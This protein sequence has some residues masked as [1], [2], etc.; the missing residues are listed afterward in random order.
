MRT[1]YA[2]LLE[3]F[4]WGVEVLSRRDCGLILSGLRAFHGECGRNYLLENWQRQRLIERQG[5]GRKAR[6]RIS[7]IGQQRLA[8]IDPHLH[9]DRTWDGKWR[10]VLYDVPETRNL[11]RRRLWRALHSRKLG[12]LQRSVWVWPHDFSRILSEIIE[13]EG[14]PKHFCGFE[15]DRLFLC[16]YQEIVDSAWDFGKIGAQHRKYLDGFAAC[17]AELKRAKDLSHLARSNG[18]RNL[19]H[20]LR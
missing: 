18:P 6:F 9:W 11:D 15:V 19:D 1:D 7:E 3:F 17:V 10:A 13:T 8:L 5:Y 12:L 14:I 16:T 2:E 4:F 20:W